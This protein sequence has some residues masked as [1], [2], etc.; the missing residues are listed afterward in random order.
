CDSP[1]SCSPQRRSP[2][3]SLRTRRP[4]RRRPRD[5]PRCS[6]SHARRAR[7]A[8]GCRCAAASR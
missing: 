3:N 7:A 5:S 6:P 2:R 8:G 1:L 4:P